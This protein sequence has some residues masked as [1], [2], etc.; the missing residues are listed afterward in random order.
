MPV[1][2]ESIARYEKASPLLLAMEDAR[3]PPERI[4]TGAATEWAREREH[5]EAHLMIQRS[6]RWSW[7]EHWA[8]IAQYGNPRRSLWLSQGGVDQPVPNSMVRGAPRANTPVP[9]PMRTEL[10]P[11]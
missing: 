7:L 5:L 10:A 8:L 9:T 4:D 11:A 6:W 1:S 3:A 2:A